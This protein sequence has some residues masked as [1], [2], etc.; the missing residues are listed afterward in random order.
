MQGGDGDQTGVLWPQGHHFNERTSRFG[1]TM[2]Q[3]MTA[4]AGS[5]TPT[6]LA[7][8]GQGIGR[9]IGHGVGEEIR[10]K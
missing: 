8:E 9:C 4:A 7:K 6:T 2:Q 10:S 5:P 3:V 1:P